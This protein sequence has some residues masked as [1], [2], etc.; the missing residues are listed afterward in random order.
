[1]ITTSLQLKGN[2]EVSFGLF[3]RADPGIDITP[4]DFLQSGFLS[5]DM[6]VSPFATPGLGSGMIRGQP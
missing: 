1:M 5:P 4:D 6:I 3:V 2:G